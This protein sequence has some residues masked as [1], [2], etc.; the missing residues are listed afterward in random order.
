VAEGKLTHKDRAKKLVE[1]KQLLEP[2]RQYYDSEFQ[3]EWKGVHDNYHGALH[4]AQTD[5]TKTDSS[6]MK[7]AYELCADASR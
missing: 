6:K 2:V 3:K 7:D 5:D 1:A 4:K